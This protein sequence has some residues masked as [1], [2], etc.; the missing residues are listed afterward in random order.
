MAIFFLVNYDR[1]IFSTRCDHGQSLA[2]LR[3]PLPT[4]LDG[5]GYHFIPKVEVPLVMIASTLEVVF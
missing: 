3:V 5:I 2:L 4:H 1:R